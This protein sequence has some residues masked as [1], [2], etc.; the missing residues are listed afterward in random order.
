M[1]FEPMR[2]FKPYLVSSEALSTTQPT[3]RSGFYLK[4]QITKQPRLQFAYFIS[5][6]KATPP[7]IMFSGKIVKTTYLPNRRV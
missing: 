6:L 2:A 5:F 4:H 7:Y 1:G 3:L